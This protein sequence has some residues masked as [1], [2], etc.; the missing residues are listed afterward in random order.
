MK[1][2]LLVSAGFCLS[3]EAFTPAN[4]QELT[5]KKVCELGKPQCVT[6]VIREM[7]QRY[8]PLA[9]QCDHDAVFALN[10]LRTTEVF[11]QTLEKPDF[12]MS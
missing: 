7:K 5:S 1:K 6:R 11:A 10:Y 12:Y 4:A 8:K 2:F 3:L 9:R